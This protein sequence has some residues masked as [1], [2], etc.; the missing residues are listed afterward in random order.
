MHYVSSSDKHMYS[1]RI[2]QNGTCEALPPVLDM[3]AF[4]TA[5]ALAA[6]FRVVRE[7]ASLPVQFALKDSKFAMGLHGR[8]EARVSPTS[9]TPLPDECH[10]PRVMLVLIHWAL[11]QKGLWSMGLAQIQ[12]NDR[13]FYTRRPTQEKASKD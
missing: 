3:I 5:S 9:P 11:L 7:H 8:D 6:F 10:T 12:E 2:R 1:T 4:L 13:C